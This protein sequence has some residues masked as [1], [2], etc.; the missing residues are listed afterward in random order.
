[1]KWIKHL[2]NDGNVFIYP[3]EDGEDY[4]INSIID[5]NKGCPEMMESMFRCFRENKNLMIIPEGTKGVKFDENLHANLFKS[6]AKD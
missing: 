4:I 2:H 5:S 6:H 3:A 1:M